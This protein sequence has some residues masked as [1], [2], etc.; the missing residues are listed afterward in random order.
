MPTGIVQFFIESKGYGYIRSE[1]SL[2]EYYVHRK[3]LTAPIQKGDRV[4]FDIQE[5]RHG[6]SAI[7][8][9]LHSSLEH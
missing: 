5:D 4:I 3:N 7:N 2:E 1:D 8:V 6:L 9:K